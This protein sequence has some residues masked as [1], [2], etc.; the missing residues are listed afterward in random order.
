[1]VC[2]SGVDVTESCSKLSGSTISSIVAG[3][4]ISLHPLDLPFEL[5]GE[6]WDNIIIPGVNYEELLASIEKY[7][8]THPEPVIMTGKGEYDSRM[9]CHDDCLCFMPPYP[10]YPPYFPGGD[11]QKPDLSKILI[12]KF[13][14]DGSEEIDTISELAALKG[15]INMLIGNRKPDANKVEPTDSN[16]N[17]KN[18][19]ITVNVSVTV[20]GRKQNP[21]VVAET[22]NTA[23]NAEDN[24]KN[25]EQI[26]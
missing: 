8:K 7:K 15:F 5:S 11:G 6:N 22:N 24:K 23:L 26:A 4:R 14:T 12:E 16:N 1:M 18:D 25:I 10:D 13:D 17:S 21:T 3:N 20:N 2:T 9:E 19:N